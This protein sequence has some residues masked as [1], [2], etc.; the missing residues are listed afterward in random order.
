MKRA[1]LS[2]ITLLSLS[3]CVLSTPLSTS[4]GNKIDVSKFDKVTV[5]KTTKAELLS[6]FGEPERT[7]RQSGYNTLNW[8]YAKASLS[9]SESQNVI[10]FLNN[11]NV[12]VDYIINPVGFII[13]PADKCGN[14]YNKTIN[15]DSI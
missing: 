11:E 12:I 14:R 8:Q 15:I 5:C 13:Q 9:G 1:I 7:G 10:V 3:G 4:I 6:L 2:S